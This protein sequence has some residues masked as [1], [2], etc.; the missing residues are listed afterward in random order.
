MNEIIMNVGKFLTNHRR[1]IFTGGSIIALGATVITAIA[2][3]KKAEVTVKEM[4]E[5]KENPVA[6]DYMKV[7]A[8]TYWKTAALFAF[9]IVLVSCNCYLDTKEITGLAS[10]CVI[11]EK[12]IVNLKKSV[13]EVAGIEQA[14]EISKSAEKKNKQTNIAE[15]R[16]LPVRSTLLNTGNGST[17]FF[18]E[19]SGRYFYSDY[20]EVLDVIYTTKYEY[21][22]M[23]E[24]CL[25]EFYEQLGLPHAT[26]FDSLYFR[27]DEIYLEAC[28]S[29]TKKPCYL[30]RFGCTPSDMSV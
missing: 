2:E 23:G 21:S 6:K 19:Y 18:D 28:M 11:S 24:G 25:G 22:T 17:L 10:A 1:A 12:K 30:I 4:T 26:C 29:D 16:N 13:K 5:K 7:Y 9:T 15:E 20:A 27:S 8:K 3:T 14:K